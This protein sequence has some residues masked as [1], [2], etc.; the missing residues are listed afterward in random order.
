MRIATREEYI[1][2]LK[3]DSLERAYLLEK[4]G[5]EIKA[6]SDIERGGDTEALRIENYN[7]NLSE[8]RDRLG[9][10][11]EK[12]L[13]DV[14]AWEAG[15]IEFTERGS[16]NPPKDNDDWVIPAF[17]DIQRA[18]V[19]VHYVVCCENSGWETA[20]KL[21]NGLVFVCFAKPEE[22][23]L[24]NQKVNLILYKREIA[25]MLEMK[26]IDDPCDTNQLLAAVHWI[27]DEYN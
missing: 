14:R 13:I 3:K 10:N 5:D 19:P 16:F 8:Y 20:D 11:L 9:N 15:G 7:F 17:L 24:N 27:L 22:M 4:D 21:P 26:R 12:A 1:N 18:D 6:Y 23:V 25:K 2:F